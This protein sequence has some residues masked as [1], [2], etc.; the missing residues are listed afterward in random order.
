MFFMDSGIHAGSAPYEYTVKEKPSATLLFKRISLIALYILWVVVLLFVGTTARIVVPF[1]A[2]IPLSLWV[3]VFLTWR[4]TQVEYEYSFF[5]GTMTVARV[6]G[7]RSRRVL[8]E[9]TISTFANVVPCTGDGLKR[10][11]NFSAERTIFAA[12]DEKAEGLYAAMWNDGENT[13]TVL[14]FEP[15]EKALKIIRYY[16]ISSLSMR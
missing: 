10:I 8:C 14:Y 4:L 16:N 3:L 6:L 15:N 9:V 11:E 7:G 2:F 12:S 13:P 5:S 1:L